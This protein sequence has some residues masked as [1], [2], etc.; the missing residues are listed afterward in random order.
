[1]L[2]TI[3][4]YA[5]LVKF[6]HTVFAMPFALIGYFYAVARMDFPFEWLLLVQI[7][8][9]MVFARNAAMAFN[10]WADRR[11]DALN[12]RTRNREIP[13]GI[14]SPSRAAWFIAINS[15]LFIATAATINH[16]TFYLS[17]LALAVILGY[18]LT[19]RFTAFCHI[20]IG[21][22]LSIAPTGAY[23]AVTGEI[24]IIPLL[25][26]AL[27]LTWV[28]GFD[29]IYSLQDAEFDRQ[30]GVNSIPS[31]IGI[32]GALVVSS[33]L[34]VIT[35][36]TT[37]ILGMFY[38][39]GTMYWIGAAIFSGLLIYQHLIVSPNNLTRVNMAFGTVN[40][41]ASIAYA[42]CVIADFY[43]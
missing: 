14:I 41:I 32:K 18:T 30:N 31:R 23:I 6:S 33:L 24:S 7:L 25:L 16:L 28:S 9:C 39:G 13:Q 21:L 17:P 15:V 11:I 35:L 26:S 10:R 43:S 19:K 20:F 34:H 27:V 4:H 1:M 8:L 29:I 38:G 40:G 37:A 12:P 5:S 2:E 3:K 36:C 42:V 22:A